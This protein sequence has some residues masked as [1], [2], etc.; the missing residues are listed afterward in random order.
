MMA[1]NN[2]V[3]TIYPLEQV[4]RIARVY[5]TRLFSDATQAV[6][7]VPVRFDEWGISFLSLSAHKLY[8]PKGVGALI[9]ASD[10]PIRPIMH[11]G[12]HQHG[13]RPGTLNVPGIVA[14]GEAC[15][16]RADEMVADESAVALKRDRLQALLVA[17]ISGLVVNG[18]TRNRLAGNLH[19]SVPDVP[20][21]AVIGRLRHRVAISTGAACS[22]GIEAPSHVL[23]AMGLPEPLLSGALRISLGKF[24]TDDEIAFAA[25][26]IA[27]AVRDARQV[28]GTAR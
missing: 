6:G 15:R 12:G 1:A 28:L 3:G 25:E 2:E 8:G 9:A 10:A 23:R 27:G 22:S 7:K 26:S 19:V 11:G 16:L 24:T 21:G 5:G 14:L 17:T 4:G 18:D 20:N 13:L